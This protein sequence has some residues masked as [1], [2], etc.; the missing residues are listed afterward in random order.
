MSLVFKSVIFL[1]SLQVGSAFANCI[2]NQMGQMTLTTC[3]DGTSHL[4]NQMGDVSISN[5]YDSRE[6]W[7]GVSTRNEFG[8]NT[9]INTNSGKSYQY[10]SNP[11]GKNG[12][13][14]HVDSQGRSWKTKRQQSGSR[15]RVQ[16]EDSYGNDVSSIEIDEM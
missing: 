3:S 7:T 9:T 6:S 5:G 1:M 8:S 2:R 4:S 12:E 10:H 16:V 11:V 13:S 15:V 14:I